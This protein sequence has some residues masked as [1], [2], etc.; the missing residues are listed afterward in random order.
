[1]R[2]S[3]I[4]FSL[5]FFIGYISVCFPQLKEDSSR[6]EITPLQINSNRG[7]FSPFLS[8]NKLYFTSGRVHRYG[9]VYID[10]DTTKELED[11]FYAVKNDSLH[12]KQ[13]HYFSE[14]INTK[15]NDGPL[16]FNKAGDV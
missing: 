2:W 9:L 6:I 1:M 3:K 10:A 4:L 7:D 5:L 12:Y 8:G 15:Y 16:C 11:I 13:V 14:K